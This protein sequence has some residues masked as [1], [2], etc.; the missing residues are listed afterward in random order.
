LFGRQFDLVQLN[1]ESSLLPQCFLFMSGHIP[2]L[3]N[4]W[5]GDN[6]TG[7]S[8]PGFDA[9]C[10]SALRALPGQPET[11][12]VQAA[13]QKLFT[14]GL[15]ALPLYWIPKVIAARPDL[16]SLNLDVSARSDFWDIETLDYGPGCQKTNQ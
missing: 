15:P 11:G 3:A 6:I 14:Q 8:D 5:I 4:H 2:T 10:S 16:C 12:T 1:W 7:F 9:A 13:A